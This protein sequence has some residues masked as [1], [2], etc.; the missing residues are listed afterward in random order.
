MARAVP[1]A[2]TIVPLG[3]AAHMGA[4]S[5]HQ[6]QLSFGIAVGSNPSAVMEN[7]CPL[8]RLQILCLFMHNLHLAGDQFLRNIGIMDNEVFNRRP[9]LEA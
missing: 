7:H 6:M 5:V 1:G 4:G 3:F 2:F 8:I 9:G